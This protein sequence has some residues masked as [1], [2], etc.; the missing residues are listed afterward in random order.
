MRN[1]LT[2][3]LLLALSSAWCQNSQDKITI[4]LHQLNQAIEASPKYNAA[5]GKT[6]E[7]FRKTLAGIKKDDLP[8]LFEG[9]HCLYEE[10]KVYNYDSAFN[11]ARQLQET[12]LQ[13]V[14]SRSAPSSPSSKEKR[15]AA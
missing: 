10:Y 6:I 12:A 4:L 15:S 11:Y 7:E 9:T 2:G 13:N 1:V 3:I 5:K 8:A 14:K